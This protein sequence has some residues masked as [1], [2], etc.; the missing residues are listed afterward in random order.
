MNAQELQ[1]QS[2]LT[3]G[4]NAQIFEGVT[5][6]PDDYVGNCKAIK[7]GNNV[8]VM[9]GAIIYGGVNI[10]DDAVVESQVILGQPEYGYAIGKTY[11][12][13]GKD[14]LVS[15][16]VV[17]RAGAIIYA[18]VQIGEET[19]IGHRTLVR[20][21]V[22]IGSNTQLGH[23]MTIERNCQIGSWVRCT[24]ITHITSSTVLEDR[25]F[26][27]ALVGTVNDKGMIWKQ[28]GLEPELIPP[29]FEY[30]CSIGT[31]AKIAAGVRVGKKAMVGTGSVVTKDV[32]PGTIVVGVPAKFYKV[33]E[34]I[35]ND[36]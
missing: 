8:R 15:K 31:G 2:L 13:E 5:F 20:T 18:G 32:A 21:D 14:T 28:E 36:V 4:N 16:G 26:L 19:T 10:Q 12:G 34:D 11:A 23:S 24:G 30:G 35:S 1:A 33:R 6:L 29:Y 27:G 22:S 7:I 3:I 25:V 9:P 17:L